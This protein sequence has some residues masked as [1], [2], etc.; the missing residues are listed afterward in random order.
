[1]IRVAKQKVAASVAVVASVAASVAVVASVA[2]VVFSGTSV[3]F[4]VKISFRLAA[5]TFV[6]LGRN[7]GKSVVVTGDSV[8]GVG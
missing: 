4:C 2:A 1:M 5:R 6:R 8:T 3:E 7:L